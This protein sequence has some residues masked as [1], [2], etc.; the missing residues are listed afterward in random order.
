MKCT[1]RLAGGPLVCIHDAGTDHEHTYHA[2]GA[3]IDA[4]TPEGQNDD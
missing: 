3:G 2:T 1:Q 4:E